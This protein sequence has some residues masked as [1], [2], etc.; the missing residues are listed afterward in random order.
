METSILISISS[1]L[2]GMI[3]NISTTIKDADFE[4]YQ[5][6]PN[7]FLS[8]FITFGLY[9]TFLVPILYFTFFVTTD[10][11][12][13]LIPLIFGLSAGFILNKLFVKKKININL[14]RLIDLILYA[15]VIL[16]Y[17]M[18]FHLNSNEYLLFDIEFIR[19]NE[20]I[21]SF[22]LATFFLFFIIFI[23]IYKSR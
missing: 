8:L 17:Y 16:I 2:A 20:I 14:P 13:S 23:K 5:R 22:F 21:Y 6:S 3:A 19:N 7:Y 10:I 9:S 4:K 1:I 15:W 11:V 18:L 12:Y